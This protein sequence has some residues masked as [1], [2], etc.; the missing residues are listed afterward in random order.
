MTSPHR[1]V[2]PDDQGSSLTPSASSALA[3]AVA[4]RGSTNGYATAVWMPAFLD[5]LAVSAD[6][7]HAARVAGVS[8][9]VV[10]SWRQSSREFREAWDHA[11]GS[12]VD[13]VEGALFAAAMG[14]DVR[15]QLAILKAHKRQHYG[16]RVGVDVDMTPQLTA[17]ARAHG[18]TLDEVRER[19]EAYRSGR[20]PLP[21]ALTAAALDDDDGEDEDGGDGAEGAGGSVIASA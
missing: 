6:V 16:D 20:I 12:C 1:P 17:L 11:V 15:A 5:A 21:V 14:G 4:G 3:R 19:Y 2:R 18:L 7:T 8:R 9:P 10:Y 13:A